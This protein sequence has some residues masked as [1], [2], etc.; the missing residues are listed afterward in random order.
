[1]ITP[2][3]YFFVLAILLMTGS[4]A[5]VHAARIV[6]A[7]NTSHR[8]VLADDPTAVERSAAA[9]LVHY[10]ARSTGA[11]FHIVSESDHRAGDQPG[12]FVGATDSVAELGIDVAQL[13]EESWRIRTRGQDLLLFG[14]GVR[15][16]MYS[17]LHFLEDHVGV[18]WWT[19]FDERVPHRPEL[20]T[21]ELDR[22]G[23]PAL[24]YREL[25][26]TGPR[27]KFHLRHR[28]NGH[29]TW[30]PP[31]HGGREG[32]G[33]PEHVHT[34]YNYVPPEKYFDEHPEYYSMVDGKRRAEKGQLCLTNSA[35]LE[36][37]K[38]GIR[39]SIEATR[40]A[41]AKKGEKSPQLFNFSYNDWR[42]LCEC[43]V[44]RLTEQAADNS[45][46][47]MFRFVNRLAES[48][49][50]D[51]PD[52]L[53]DTIA[54]DRTF[55]P[56]VQPMR[57]NVVVRIA[58]LKHRDFSTPITSKANREYRTVFDLWR[59]KTPHLRVWGYAV[60]FGDHSNLPLPNLSVLAEDLR[61]YLAND[62]EGVLFQLEYPIRADLRELKM[63]VLLKLIEDPTR[64]VSRLVVEFTDGFYGLA[65]EPIRSYVTLIENA[66][67]RK[68][69]RIDYPNK[70]HEYDYLDRKTLH[71]AH[72]LFDQAEQMVHDD[73]T[74]LE[75]VRFARVSL[76]RATL[77]RW[78]RAIARKKSDLDPEL[79]ATR[80]LDVVDRRIA[81][82]YSE[83]QRDEKR[84]VFLAEIGES[85]QE[86]REGR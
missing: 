27:W 74:M 68:P 63:W 29:R 26:G 37:V 52:V 43:E 44:C 6:S 51:Y 34:A 36:L 72:E 22:A 3:R 5:G 80:L 75:R 9:E 62:V 71:A 77:L 57:D 50:Q 28:L 86:I 58:P 69:S 10:L 40:R 76:D 54:Y 70:P 23:R 13:P 42:K 78:N 84:E 48:I 12:I 45:G 47:T 85:L 61:Y 73:A 46:A 24:R 4:A 49:E 65:A 7:G 83:H 15:G 41:S 55:D 53:I 16:T 32:Y 59:K 19:P 39:E 25:T 60:T 82:V 17:V 14:G 81:R 56:P 20:G 30:I 8:V 18:R 66:A 79:I 35:V 1:M 38:T 11:D 33:L 2:T 64:D 67:A 21:P 31:S